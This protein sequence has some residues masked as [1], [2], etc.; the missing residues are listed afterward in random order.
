VWSPLN[1]DPG[2]RTARG[3]W[4]LPVIG[5]LRPGIS[6]AA[7]DAEVAT[8]AA[9][10]AK[11]YPE[12]NEGVGG[13]VGDLRESL[14]GDT[15]RALLVLMG[16]VGLVLLIACVNVANL[17]LS[18][19][20]AREPELALRTA[21]GAGRGRLV[22]QLLTESVLLGLC[23]GLLGVGLASVGTDA[24]LAMQAR[25]LPR[26]TDIHL[27][28]GVLV[29]AALL[30]MGTGLFFGLAPA[31]LMARRATAQSLREGG[32]GL[33]HGRGGRL[34]GGLV[35]AEIALA[36]V[37]LAGAG[38]LVRS[39][40]ELRR[41][42]PGFTTRNALTFRLSLPEAAYPDPAQRTQWYG[43][44]LARLRAL[45]G[46]E[47]AGGVLALPLSGARWSFSFEVDGRPNLPPAQ[48][49]SLETRV[50]TP[51]YFRAL[52][53]PIVRGRGF[54]ER[55]VAT[56]P[57]VVLL[58]ESAV[59]EH[60]PDEEPIGRRIALGWG[61]AGLEAVGGEIVGIVADVKE[62]GLGKPSPPQI[63]LP[64]AQKPIASLSVVVRSKLPPASLAPA[65]RRTLVELDPAL[66][67]A[68][69]ASLDE[70]M[71]RS[72]AEPRFNALLLG[73]F[74][75]T[76]LLL[77]A[78]GIFGVTSHAVAQ[79]EREIGVRVALGAEPRAVPSLVMRGAGR[80][81]V[82]GLA[83][84]LALSRG[85]ASLLF[86]MSPTDPA[87]LGAVALGLGATALLASALPAVRATHVDPLVALRS[88]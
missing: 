36:M 65:V 71:A 31:L 72:I 30:S 25:N 44:L 24:L 14:V 87:T 5:R 29:L 57:R 23:G 16:A 32:R 12:M 63:Y 9:R 52:G 37:L 2:F 80:L 4:Y 35:V 33:L 69:L 67:L 81:V 10:L 84:S 59:R 49:P 20:V 3:A 11:A 79:R 60:F 53:L 18:R 7:A 39:F 85:L 78:L 22:G 73:A 50:A 88:E 8:I 83:G 54:T 62:Q 70:V 56:A 1:Y 75:A 64:Y 86:N 28:G 34:H 26:A 66:P 55:D 48:Q 61:G 38:L 40:N 58:S 42:D 15:R 21:L 46:V 74:A 13:A 27:D 17:L 43:E 19:V 76:A 51:G 6:V 47:A 41:V 82:L 68:R 45:P 77:A